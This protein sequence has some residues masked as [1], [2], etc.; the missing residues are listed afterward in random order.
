MTL[1][2]LRRASTWGVS[3]VVAGLG[4][5][6]AFAL[7]GAT[8]ADADEP[9]TGS[10][11]ITMDQA[12]HQEDHDFEFAGCGTLGC[13]TFVLNPN[14]LD[15]TSAR[16][17][18]VPDLVP[19]TYTVTQ[20]AVANWPL[21]T[22]ACDTG[23]T[24]SVA[25]RRATI[26]L[27]AGEDVHCTFTTQTQRLLIVED[28]TPDSAL[29]FEFTGCSGTGCGS[30]T[31][32]DD[33]DP[34]LERSAQAVGLAPGTYVIT[35]AAGAPLPLSAISCSSSENVDV[36]ARRVTVT[37]A[38]NE[39]VT[40]TF[41]N[42]APAITIT[43]DTVPD[44]AHD[45]GFTG[46]LG[47]G[48]ATFAFDDDTDPGLPRSVTSDGLSS[49]TYTVTQSPE[50][51][52]PLTSITC[53]TGESVDLANR[54]VTI[55]LGAAERTACTFKN[56]S[57][58]LT[59]VE[60][61]SPDGPQDFTLE[62][63]AGSD[64]TDVI[65]D[66][67]FDETRPGSTGKVP[68]PA[69]TYVV[70]ADEVDGFEL[71]SLSCA[72]AESVDLDARQVTVTL[73]VA[74]QQSCTFTHRPPPP[75]LSGVTEIS[76][77]NHGTCAR[78]TNGQARCW[79]LGEAGR[80]GDGTFADTSVPVAVLLPDGSG[81][82]T[83][84]DSISTG[85]AHACAAL[86][87]GQARC[88]GYGGGGTLGN[89]GTV[90]SPLPVAVSDSAGTGAL[91]GVVD[92][93]A[94]GGHSCALLSTGQVNCWGANNNGQL[95]DGSTTTR[96]RPVTVSDPAGTGPLGGVN[97]L[98]V[99][100]SR[101][102]VVVTGGEVR[103][104][105]SN[106]HGGL[107]DGTTTDRTRPV[108][109]SDVEGTGPLIGA[110]QV[111]AGSS[112]A[113]AL[114]ES[115]EG[116][117]WGSNQ[118]GQLGDGTTTDS[119][120]PVVISNPD[121]TGPLTG[122]VELSVLDYQSCALVESGS[123]YCWGSN[124]TGAL[125]DGTTTDHIRPTPVQNVE[126]TG[127]LTDVAQISA[128]L[129]HTCATLTNSEARCWGSA[130]NGGLGDGTTGVRRLRPVPVVDPAAALV[131]IS[132]VAETGAGAAHTCARSDGGGVACWGSN[133]WGQLGTADVNSSSV[134]V[135]VS[136]RAGDGPLADV[137]DLAVGRVHNCVALSGGTAACWGNN[138]DHRLGDGTTTNR[139][140]PVTV[141]N[142]EGT[143]PLTDVAQVSAGF[144]HSCAVLADTTAR[145]WGTNSRGA[146][147]DGTTT[148]RTLPVVV[149]DETGSGPLTGIAQIELGEERSCA[150][151]TSGQVRC[152]GPTQPLPVVVS[153]PENTGP[154]TNVTAVAVG[155]DHTCARLGT[156]QVACWTGTGSGPGLTVMV[157][158]PSGTGPL[159]GVTSI[160]ADSGRT[161]V[162]FDD[163][164]AACWG[165]MP[166]GDGTVASRVLPTIVA[167]LET[168]ADVTVGE[169][170][171]CV[172]LTD[173]QAR[174]WGRNDDGRVGDGTGLGS[175]A[176]Q[177]RPRVVVVLAP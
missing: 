122:I 27:T 62:R 134:P 14:D 40:C 13:G 55:T 164:A 47:T 42:Q 148:N 29:D 163:G 81:P 140:R 110:T 106:L 6:A 152:W 125:G 26:T 46:C 73:D 113:C 4:L 153:N 151:L 103:C 92:V 167:G 143:G 102:C 28:T 38:A 18:T 131:P 12:R 162:G 31:L 119:S 100:L 68:L 115:G 54:R 16:S 24:V 88:W 118:N 168:V 86:T 141:S 37:L 15:G 160:A 144:S 82:L 10:I 107:G 105:G 112:H 60:D 44:D 33:A 137:T 56:T 126:G 135:T 70:T 71:A 129:G 123:V 172:T 35:Q 36:A 32:D 23:E 11:T 76:A 104:W 155:Y 21:K 124:I 170:H 48:C 161:C 65:L 59:L 7:L 43:Q 150:V 91:T 157:S 58:T 57:A 19:G 83:D 138:G 22:L 80:V 51:D 3:A 67:D 74:E 98:S 171:N 5:A 166:I 39:Y 93:G 142:P 72:T 45:F 154:L 159:S 52:W 25:E 94:G 1:R 84:V 121:G 114:L 111:T 165:N 77:G 175:A 96:R 177:L 85:F 95:G 128:G 69:G 176:W 156:G 173:G 64:C 120:R 9:T 147:G 117:C 139:L 99:G 79:G 146:L 145:C 49:G 133:G 53:T 109:V 50:A 136:N 158:N 89:G 132:A 8:R 2:G 97:H 75:H 78:L 127:S 63:C 101:T 34:T 116:R 108:A 130:G 87:T 61:T 66:D 149:R 30:F 90:D 41:K 169:M 20:T 17:M 174:C